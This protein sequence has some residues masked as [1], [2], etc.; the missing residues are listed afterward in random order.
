MEIR[1]EN[2]LVT[3][4]IA[5]DYLS[6]NTQ[7]RS[8]SVHRV[9]AYADDMANGRWKFNPLP[10]VF[11]I[12]GKLIDGQHRLLAIIKAGVPVE[13]VV[14]F[15]APDESM[16]IIDSG[17]PRSA[18]DVLKIDG[19]ADSNNVCATAKRII[20]YDNGLAAIL[21]GGTTSHI[22]NTTKVEVIEYV[23]THLDDL[24]NL[25]SNAK[26]IY[27]YGNITLLAPSEIAFF[28]YAL[29]PPESASEFMTKVISGVGLNEGTP[30]LAIR[31][32]LE[33]VRFKRDLMTTS[34]ELTQYVFV[35]FGKYVKGESCEVLRL[36]KSAKR[37]TSDQ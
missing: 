12:S 31:R 1:T 24:H 30:E 18:S 4:S 37:Q 10:I 15:G 6:K 26:S 9:L 32:I 35:A 22:H 33:R 29:K 17:K 5:E 36:P 7:N 19:V 8:V 28:L 13:S 11:S 14:M 27:K 34:A 23:R 21:Q 20:G 16:D 2:I 25:V 3:P